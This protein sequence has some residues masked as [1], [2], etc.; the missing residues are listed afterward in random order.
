MFTIHE[1]I[2]SVP[3]RLRSPRSVDFTT[4]GNNFLARST[5]NDTSVMTRSPETLKR[6]DASARNDQ[7]VAKGSCPQAPMTLVPETP[8]TVSA[9]GKLLPYNEQQKV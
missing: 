9:G 1:A 5:S 6:V 2:V 3:H 4:T 8:V 7:F